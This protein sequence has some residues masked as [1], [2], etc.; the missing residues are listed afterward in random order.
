MSEYTLPHE[1]AG[2]R[3]RLD[4]MSELLDPLQRSL[5]QQLGL[6][7]GWRCLEVGCGNGSIS[8]WLAGQVQPSGQVLATDIDIRYLEGLN[9]PCLDVQ[10]LNILEDSVREGAYDLV[11]ARALLHH[12][13][14]PRE[15]V[16]RL[17]SA[18]RPA[19]VLILIEPDF[20]P[21]TAAE[22]E[23]VSRFWEAWLD[24]SK[25]EGID[26]FVGRKIPAMLA[27][28]GLSAVGAEGYTAIYRGG[29]KWA[30][31]WLE[32]LEELQPRIIQSGYATESL[33][34]AFRALYSDSN[35]WT[36]AITFIA[37]YGHKA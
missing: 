18:L 35:Y 15:V 24:W 3:R 19:G 20:L 32:T 34:S 22:P 14:S 33:L 16:R 1:L 23:A 28:L 13:A 12:L 21:A 37:S 29:S 27:E 4:L 30:V 2:E 17:I 26:Y 10:R 11:T 9:T 5:L 6:R 36:S 31:Y 7:S 8:E 25:S